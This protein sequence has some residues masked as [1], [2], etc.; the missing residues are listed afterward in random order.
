MS[1]I[2]P[3]DVLL[4]A[5]AQ[6][7]FPMAHDGEIRWFSPERRGL[8]PLDER[9]HI[10]HGLKRALKRQ[11]FEL[12]WNTAFREVMLA[13]AARKETWI[14]DVILES[15]CALHAEGFAH[16]IE[17]WDADGLQG[18]LYGV[19]LPGVFFGESMFSRKSDAS[20]IA[21]VALIEQLRARKF[22]MLDTQ[23]MTDHLR[24]F[25][26]YEMTRKQYQSALHKIFAKTIGEK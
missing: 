16:S 3:A 13:C 5:Y 2:I 7:V 10:P 12:R 18:G 14:D 24:Q 22:Q 21:L 17:C 11:P 23:W 6:G 9:F 19:E 15:Y 4:D 25:G 20:K 8:I 26:G 1:N